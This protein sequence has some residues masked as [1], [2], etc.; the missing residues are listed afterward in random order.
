[1]NTI[2]PGPIETPIFGKLGIP[3]D[4]IAD[5][6]KN[7]IAKIPLA[8]FGHAGEVASV[9]SGCIPQYS[10]ADHGRRFDRQHSFRRLLNEGVLIAPRGMIALS[11]PMT[12]GNV[13]A[14]LDA[15]DR[16]ALTLPR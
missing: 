14:F 1:M 7:A 2:S 16:V 5:F 8:R 10:G 4:A 9:R 11:T 15:V 6:S 13:R 3:A 12:D